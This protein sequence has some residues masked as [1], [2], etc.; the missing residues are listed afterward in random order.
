MDGADE[1]NREIDSRRLE[2]AVRN[3]YVSR[4][5]RI[6]TAAQA[7]LL[8]NPSCDYDPRGS[9]HDALLHADALIAQLDREGGG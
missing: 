9:A 8:S 5:E 4:R 7:A 3:N 6:A 1:A 2:S